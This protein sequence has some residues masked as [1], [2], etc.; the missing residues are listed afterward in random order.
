MGGRFSN[1][2]SALDTDI[3]QHV[4]DALALPEDLEG[5]PVVAARPRH[6]SHGTYTS[7]RK[8]NLDLDGPIA[9]AF[10]RSGPP[11]T[12]K[13]KRPGLYPRACDSGTREK[14]VRT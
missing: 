3:L 10:L 12:L 6:C 7:G 1:N 2:T 5:L 11:A 14:R 8:C 13:E 9:A 4:G